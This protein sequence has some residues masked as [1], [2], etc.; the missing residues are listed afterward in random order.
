MTNNRTI[1][2]SVCAGLLALLCL[3]AEAKPP[4][5]R[6]PVVVEAFG[7]AVAETGEPEIELRRIAIEDALGNAELQAYVDVE[8]QTRIEDMRIKEKTM[9]LSGLGSA[10]L[11]RIL[12]AGYETNSIPPRLYR[13]HVEARV[14]P[15]S[16]NIS[17]PTPPLLV[18]LTVQSRPDPKLGKNLYNIL[19]SHLEDRGIQ[20][21]DS[22]FKPGTVA[23]DITLVQLAGNSSMELQWNV[24][25]R[26]SPGANGCFTTGTRLVPH[27][28]QRPVELQKLGALLAGEV[29]RIASP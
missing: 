7:F 3:S 21:A 16:K 11:L 18:A 25:R 27:P 4:G 9:R 12:E 2:I 6:H 23:M 29:E 17:R 22:P 8:M 14:Y 13:V 10:E 19:V 5:V 26:S 20:I 24:K 28:G 1:S 15:T